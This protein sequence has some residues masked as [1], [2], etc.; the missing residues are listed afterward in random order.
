MSWCENVSKA[1]GKSATLHPR[2]LRQQSSGEEGGTFVCVC[3][4]IYIK[5]TLYIDLTLSLFTTHGINLTPPCAASSL[6]DSSVCTRNL[7]GK[8]RPHNR[9]LVQKG[10]YGGTSCSASLGCWFVLFFSFY[11]LL[12]DLFSL[13]IIFDCAEEDFSTMRV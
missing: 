9:R 3:V 1:A 13:T 11:P 6:P 12:I 7:R 8:V 2:R 5:Y 4:Y 10:E